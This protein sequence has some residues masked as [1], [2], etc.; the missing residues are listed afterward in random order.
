MGIA[1]NKHEELVGLMFEK[2]VP[3]ERFYKPTGTPENAAPEKIAIHVYHL[4]L[5]ILG[6]DTELFQ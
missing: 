3:F 1:A 5:A 6:R 2:A 4:D